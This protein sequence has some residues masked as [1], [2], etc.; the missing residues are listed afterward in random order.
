MHTQTFTT[1]TRMPE[2]SRNTTA[3]GM[4]N[5]IRHARLDQASEIRSGVCD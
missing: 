4:C 5:W 1:Y 2:E 3:E